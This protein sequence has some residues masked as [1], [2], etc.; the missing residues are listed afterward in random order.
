[1]SIAPSTVSVHTR[2]IMVK[3]G[4][5]SRESIIDFI[6]QSHKLPNLREYYVS[7]T[8]EAAFAAALKTLSKL[9]RKENW[10]GGYIYGQ[11]KSLKAVLVGHLVGHL[12]H[13]GIQAVIEEQKKGCHAKII[14]HSD[15][16]LFLLIEKEAFQ[17]IPQKHPQFML[18]NLS[19]EKN[20]FFAVFEIL[21]KLISDVNFE[22]IFKKFIEQYKGVGNSSGSGYS[23]IYKNEVL[24]K[25]E[26]GDLHKKMQILRNKKWY[27]VSVA[28]CV[29]L[30]CFV[31]YIFKGNKE[32]QIGQGHEELSEPVIRSD[33]F[34]PTESVLLHRPDEIAQIE[35][36]FKG[37]KGIQTIVLVGPGGIGKTT[38]SRQYAHRQKA[39][40]IWEINAETYESL[41]SS[42]EDL[43]QAL[44][45]TEKDQKILAGLQDTKDPMQ[46]EKKLIEFVKKKLKSYPYWFLIYDN[47]KEFQDIQKYFPQDG[48]TWGHGKIILTTRNSNTRNHKHINSAIQ[49]G[50]LNPNQKLT[51]FMKIMANGSKRSFTTAQ[52]EEAKQFLE[53]I[54]SYPLDVSIAAYYLETT[55][56]PYTAYLKNLAQN[57]KGFANI[58]EKVL[59][60]VGDYTKTRYGIITLSLQQLINSHQNFSSLLLFI[61]LLDS[62][63]IPRDLLTT[64]KND[65]IIDNFILSLKKYS[66]ITNQSLP[67]S[68]LGSTF[69]MHR[70]TQEISLTYLRK[71]LNLE[72]NNQLFQQIFKVLENYIAELIEK[73]DL[74]KLRVLISHCEMFLSHDNL[75][76]QEMRRS[77]AGELGGI[78]LYL[79]N[80][81]KAK[82][83]L[84]KNLL[85]LNQV[86]HLGNAR[87]L[88]YLGNVYGD[89]GNYEKAKGLLEQSLLIYKKYFPENHAGIARALSYLGNVH[90]DLG[91]FEEAKDL[92]EQSLLIYKTYFPENHLGNARTS[93]YLGI[94]HTILENY[95]KAQSLLE[96]SLLIYQNHLSKNH[97]GVAWV[98]AHLGDVYGQLQDYEK[99][100]TLFEQ[101][102]TLYK[103]H[104]PEDHIKT[105]WA[106]S[107]LG[108]IYR[109]LG[110]YEKAKNTLEESLLIYKKH[111]SENNIVVAGILVYLGLVYKDS[112]NYE[113]AKDLLEQ[114][115][116]LYKKHFPKDHSEVAWA[117]AH[118]G[119]TY[120]TMGEHEK[121]KLLLEESV[122]I[123]KKHFSEN[124]SEVIWASK[125][126]NNVYHELDKSEKAKSLSE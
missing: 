30:F 94:V 58:Q 65:L 88:A 123:Y 46:R 10:A 68:L 111:L 28:F 60:E 100:R 41:K 98:L 81:L 37:E 66:L 78:Y 105:G 59:S 87:A 20:Y 122:L 38:L 70:S 16:L 69:S 61:S 51:L 34:I 13:A 125:C 102:I 25:I 24:E 77:I 74:S 113:K 14:R 64:Y 120:R 71:I 109:T 119:D 49:I 1:M 95:E 92:L 43:A 26:E 114:S 73:E 63:N 103:E 22:G 104:F 31:F 124:H 6:E 48:E 89:L 85:E 97:D 90:R 8:I 121:A 72:K 27:F 50:E 40:V 67:S 3:L 84:E 80:Y 56:I 4:H 32:M 96:Q 115:L 18:I 21:R 23:H 12:K 11:N 36:Q 86:D 44:A 75:L 39:R 117:L 79:G 54:P 19:E 33:L 108:D 106:L 42:F 107:S 101:S 110:D 126:L 112:G 93:A 52:K 15:K 53:K 99:A 17:E 9:K 118:L 116:V 5:H 2:N 83:L 76:T 57:K 29:G 47:M 35:E 82:Q 91:N 55:T 62:Q 7:L 45:I